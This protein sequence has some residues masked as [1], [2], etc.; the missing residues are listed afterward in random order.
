MKIKTGNARFRTHKMSIY[1]ISYRTIREIQMNSKF[2]SICGNR[3]CVIEQTTDIRN[4]KLVKKTL[5]IGND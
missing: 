1:I 4:I 3:S 2:I 5:N